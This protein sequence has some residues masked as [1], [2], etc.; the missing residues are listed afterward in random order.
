MIRWHKPSQ[1]QNCSRS[2]YEHIQQ[3]KCHINKDHMDMDSSVDLTILSFFSTEREHLCLC[4]SRK[5]KSTR[6]SAD[7]C[8]WRWKQSNEV[9]TVSKKNQQASL[10]KNQLHT[11][12]FKHQIKLLLIW[13]W[14]CWKVTTYIYS[15]T[16]LKYSFLEYFLFPILYTPLHLFDY[17]SHFTDSD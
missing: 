3:Q 2:Q 6:S 11:K 9:A 1:I 15:S 13:F 10:K 5:C 4:H 7:R 12:T 16:E 17:F 14:Q 8:N